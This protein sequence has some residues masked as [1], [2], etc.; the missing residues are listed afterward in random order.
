L[1]GVTSTFNGEPWDLREPCRSCGGS[2][3]TITTVNGQDTVRCAECSRHAYNAPRIATG[4][5]QRSLRTRPDIKPSQRARI[6]MRDGSACVICHA[7]DTQLDVG[8]LIDV[9]SGRAEGLTDLELFD[10]ENLA[11]MCAP[12]NSGLGDQP[13]PLKLAIRILVIRLTSLRA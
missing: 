2:E 5:E 13:L 1:G 11:V 9:K 4:R 7:G 10:D 6:F 8:H 12:C 3:G